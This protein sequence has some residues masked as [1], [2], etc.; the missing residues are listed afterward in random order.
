MSIHR[1]TDARID[2]SGR[3]FEFPLAKSPEEQRAAEVAERLRAEQVAARL[4][5]ITL[6]RGDV[7]TIVNGRY[8]K[9]TLTTQV[10]L[11]VVYNVE[12]GYIRRDGNLF[13]VNFADAA[14]QPRI[15]HP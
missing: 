8:A 12:Q 15:F 3:S 13:Q 2:V 10:A 4:R 7:V 14:I 9:L 1:V 5:G 11:G 6:E